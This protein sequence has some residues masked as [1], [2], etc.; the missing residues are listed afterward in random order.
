MNAL[1]GA[2]QS[3][4]RRGD[5]QSTSTYRYRHRDVGITHRAACKQLDAFVVWRRQSFM[6]GAEEIESLC[7]PLSLP[8]IRTRLSNRALHQPPDS[9]LW[10]RGNSRRKGTLFREK[11]RDTFSAFPCHVA[12]THHSGGCVSCSG[13]ESWLP[14]LSFREELPSLRSRFSTAELVGIRVEREF[15][16]TSSTLKSS[17]DAV[18]TLRSRMLKSDT[19]RES[20]YPAMLFS[21]LRQCPRKSLWP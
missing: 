1:L 10:G 6:W 15:L 7:A 2:Q 17:G 8:Y 20:I 19:A 12:A 18:S 4:P 3:A 16:G 13:G 14:A 21:F 5:L 9:C 11:S